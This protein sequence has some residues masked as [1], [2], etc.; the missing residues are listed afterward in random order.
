[1]GSMMRATPKQY[2]AMLQDEG[3]LE[4][5]DPK[6][7]FNIQGGYGFIGWQCGPRNG[8]LTPFHDKRVRRAM[9]HLIDR[10]NVTLG[11]IYKN[12]GRVATSP[13][14][15]ETPQSNPA[16][17]PWPYDV[18]RARELLAEAGWLDRNNNGILENENGVEFRFAI[19][20]GQGSE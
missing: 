18:D 5:Y 3:F 19:T 8:R 14:S 2:E 1:Q 16:I 4:K 15:S 11:D 10:E 20:F 13:F 12:L 17:E 9:T 6:M 7:W